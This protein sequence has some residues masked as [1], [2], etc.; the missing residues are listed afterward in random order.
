[1]LKITCFDI[2]VKVQRKYESIWFIAVVRGWLDRKQKW[3]DN[4]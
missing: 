1:M 3:N 2:Y 4:F